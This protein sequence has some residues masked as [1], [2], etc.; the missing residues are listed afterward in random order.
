METSIETVIVCVFY[1]CILLLLAYW[2]GKE[3]GKAIGWK[4][5]YFKHPA[6]IRAER[7]MRDKNGRF[8][9]NPLT[10]EG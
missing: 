1:A 7:K 3:K 10:P 9:K 6:Q 8:K 4:D 2:F 5:G